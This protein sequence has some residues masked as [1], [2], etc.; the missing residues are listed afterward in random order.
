MLL[1]RIRR[2]ES[3]AQSHQG[4]GAGGNALIHAEFLSLEFLTIW[5]KYDSHTITVHPFKVQF[6][7]FWYILSCSSITTSNFRTFSS[8]H[9]K[10]L[11]LLTIPYS[12]PL[13]CTPHLPLT[14]PPL[15]PGATAPYLYAFV[16]SGH[17]SEWN[18]TT[19]GLQCW[20][21]SFRISGCFQGSST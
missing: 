4:G 17:F 18:N 7:G 12:V 5:L 8:S 9:H 20:R 13:H 19:C 10:A 2:F 16:G 15:Q 14:P 1:H 21:L 3:L 11:Y 6:T